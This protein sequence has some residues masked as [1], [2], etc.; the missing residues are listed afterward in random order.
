MALCLRLVTETLKKCTFSGKLLLPPPRSMMAA[1]SSVTDGSFR[2]WRCA[3]GSDCI[4]PTACFYRRRRTDGPTWGRI[5][6]YGCCYQSGC[7]FL[8]RVTNSPT[9]FIRSTSANYIV[10]KPLSN[11]AS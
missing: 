11:F 9:D 10:C 3:E 8:S 7:D 6:S 2:R 5:S 4:S 1:G